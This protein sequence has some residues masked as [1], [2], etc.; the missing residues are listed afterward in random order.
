M[1]RRRSPHSGL[2]HV[3]R[4]LDGRPLLPRQVTRYA[5]GRGHRKLGGRIRRLGSGRP[6]TA[7]GMGQGSTRRRKGR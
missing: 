6:L 2:S 7:L 4:I 3:L 1:G 5:G